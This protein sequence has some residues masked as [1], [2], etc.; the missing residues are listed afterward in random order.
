MVKESMV[1]ALLLATVALL[2]ACTGTH[3]AMQVV[4][5]ARPSLQA[6]PSRHRSAATGSRRT[7]GYRLAV[8]E[9][10]RQESRRDGILKVAALEIVARVTASKLACAGNCKFAVRMGGKH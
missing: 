5:R 3:V 4:R 7:T 8:A 1:R 6:W 10:P 2:G 9:R